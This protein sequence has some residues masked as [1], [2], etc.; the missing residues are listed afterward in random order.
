[1]VV[2]T[3]QSLLDRFLS[4]RRQYRSTPKG[5]ICVLDLHLPKLS[6]NEICVLKVPSVWITLE[7]GV[8]NKTL[9]MLLIEYNMQACVKSWSSQ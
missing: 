3:Y 5:R 8:G 1:M 2:L 4:H 9:P 7:A 6:I